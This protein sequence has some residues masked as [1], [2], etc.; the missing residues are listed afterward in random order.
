MMAEKTRLFQDH[1]A[2]GLIM[3]SPCPNTRK[4]IGQAVRNFFSAVGDKES[5]HAVL[6]CTYTK[7]THTPA[8]KRYLF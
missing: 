1:R 7:F 8:M 5:Q 4:G 6:S 3:S 2:V